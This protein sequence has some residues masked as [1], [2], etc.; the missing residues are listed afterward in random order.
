MLCD[1]QVTRSLSLALAG[2]ALALLEHSLGATCPWLPW[3][4]V[5][6]ERR[7]VLCLSEQGLMLG[8]ALAPACTPAAPGLRCIPAWEELPGG[9]AKTKQPA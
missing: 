3:V 7:S 1:A 5:R 6:G 8:T 9:L 2:A 4:R